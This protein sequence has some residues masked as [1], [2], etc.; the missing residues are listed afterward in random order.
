MG[1]SRARRPHIPFATVAF[2]V[3][4]LTDVYRVA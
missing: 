1:S 2:L 3:L 4:A